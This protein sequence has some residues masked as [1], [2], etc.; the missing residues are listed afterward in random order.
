[1]SNKDNNIAAMEA[2]ARQTVL[3]NAEAEAEA[4]EKAAQKAA[5]ELLADAKNKADAVRH[6]AAVKAAE[7][8]LAAGSA[9]APR[10]IDWCVWRRDPSG[11]PYDGGNVEYQH[12]IIDMLTRRVMEATPVASSK[13][14]SFAKLYRR[15]NP[16]LRVGQ[17]LPSDHPAW[18]K[19]LGVDD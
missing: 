14:G 13:G 5:D 10:Q 17:V 4:I 18:S 9:A 11:M 12:V 8:E 15:I 3:S 1:M 6:T 19:A 2:A 16:P 7:M